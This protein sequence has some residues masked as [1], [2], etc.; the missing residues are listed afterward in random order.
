M[1][2]VVLI[3]FTFRNKTADSTDHINYEHSHILSPHCNQKT[4]RALLPV[5]KTSYSTWPSMGAV[6]GVIFQLSSGWSHNVLTL[7]LSGL[8]RP[9][10]K[11]SHNAGFRASFCILVSRET[12]TVFVN[13][14]KNV[15]S[16]WIFMGGT[17]SR[18]N[19]SHTRSPVS[20]YHCF[21]ENFSTHV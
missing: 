11:Q 2:Q 6:N 3:Q 4:F 5:M 1:V 12:I 21:F 19:K 13:K 18:F 14:W 17:S 10:Y 15:I 7:S 8:G 16:T 20:L 9:S